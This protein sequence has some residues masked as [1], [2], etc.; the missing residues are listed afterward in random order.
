M[1]E[2]TMSLGIFVKY[3]D[4]QSKE[5]KYEIWPAGAE[6]SRSKLW[7]SPQLKGF[8][9]RLLPQIENDIVVL[10]SEFD[11]LLAECATIERWCLNG[12]PGGTAEDAAW[13][14]KFND[15]MLRYID[16]FRNAV[17]FARS[18]GAKEL[19]VG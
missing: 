1:K 15:R 18:V 10:Q 12:C 16:N 5:R 2:T 4:P 14:R 19:E 7:G 6:D 13:W 8:N 17:A 9:L 11:E 3:E